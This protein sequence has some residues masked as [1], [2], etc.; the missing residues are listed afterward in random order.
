M[1]LYIIRKVHRISTYFIHVTLTKCASAKAFLTTLRKLQRTRGKTTQ[2]VKNKN[3][4][5][6]DKNFI[7]YQRDLLSGK[8]DFTKFSSKGYESKILLFPHCGK[9]DVRLNEELVRPLSLCVLPLFWVSWHI[10][11]FQRESS[12]IF[13]F[14]LNF[15]RNLGNS[16]PIL[17]IKT[18]HFLR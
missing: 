6:L 12:R 11:P 4:L 15:R 1:Y 5:S 13:S 16:N 2:C 3:F 8:D 18:L 7:N 14:C 10:P 17:L 9:N